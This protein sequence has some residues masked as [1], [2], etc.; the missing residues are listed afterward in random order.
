MDRLIHGSGL[1]DL[2]SILGAFSLSFVHEGRR[3]KASSLDFEHTT[4][5]QYI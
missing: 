1:E 4:V 2:T 3:I 5:S